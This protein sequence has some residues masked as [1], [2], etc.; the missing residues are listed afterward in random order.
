VA[1][2]FLTV[3]LDWRDHTLSDASLLRP[4]EILTSYGNPSKAASILGW[5]AKYKMRDV[6]QMMTAS[7]HDKH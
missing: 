5:K 2:A 4:S 6:V 7:I 1:E 3:G